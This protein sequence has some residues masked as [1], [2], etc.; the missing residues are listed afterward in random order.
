M[1]TLVN[2]WSPKD[3][4]STPLKLVHTYMERMFLLV[5]NV[6]SSL[7]LFRS[8]LK[9]RKDLLHPLYIFSEPQ[10]HFCFVFC[11]VL[12]RRLWLQTRYICGPTQRKMC[13]L[14]RLNSVAKF[15]NL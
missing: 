14:W 8:D 7:H 3:S 15:K 9:N 12:R 11:F 1:R 4:V 2:L 13:R 6:L 10:L 5:P